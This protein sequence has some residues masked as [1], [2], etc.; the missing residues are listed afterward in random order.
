[1]GVGYRMVVLRDGMVLWDGMGLWDELGW[2]DWDGLGW[3]EI[4]IA[5]VARDRTQFRLQRWRK[6][7][8]PWSMRREAAAT[9]SIEC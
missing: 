8:R 4:R 2:E 9:T 5:R 3:D 7:D 6:N 1:M